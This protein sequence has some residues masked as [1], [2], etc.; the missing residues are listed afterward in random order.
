MSDSPSSA[1]EAAAALSPRPLLSGLEQK[2]AP[3]HTALVV[4]DVQNDF[5]AEGGMMDKEGMDLRPVQE[6]AADLPRLIGE[7]RS[8]GALVVFVRN[9]YSTEANHYLSDVWLEQA[10]RRRAGSYTV[11]PV[12]TPGSWEGDFYGDVRPLPDEPVIT[13]HRFSA[14]HNTDLET[15]LRARSIRTIVLAGIATNVCVETTAREA[16]VRDYYVVFLSDGTATY[17][18]EAHD[19]TLSVVDQFFGQVAS[20]DEVIGCWRSARSGTAAPLED[21][22]LVQQA[23]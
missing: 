13:K 8:A 16:F 1:F 2:V 7:A 9:V 17:D 18:R 5:C 14:F 10:S 11:R 19:A 15:V 20:M 3:A 4:V 6:L 21:A 23:P 12:C 22:A